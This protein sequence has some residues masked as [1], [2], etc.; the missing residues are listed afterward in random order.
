MDHH[1]CN[2]MLVCMS[3]MIVQM[4]SRAS[5]VNSHHYSKYVGSSIGCT[6]SSGLCLDFVIILVGGNRLPSHN[7]RNHDRLLR[8]KK[9]V[10]AILDNRCY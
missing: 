7:M 5:T 4:L 2:T 10:I 8:I 6:R 3:T 1:E 9:S